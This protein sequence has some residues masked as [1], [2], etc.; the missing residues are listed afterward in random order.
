MGEC[1]GEGLQWVSTVHGAH[2][3]TSR[4]DVRCILEGSG[5][6]DGIWGGTNQEECWQGRRCFFRE[7]FMAHVEL[8]LLHLN[9]LLLHYLEQ[10]QI[11]LH[12]LNSLLVFSYFHLRMAVLQ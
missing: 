6:R 10:T 9:D 2:L 1:L 7:V 3:K 8:L 11:K 4:Q 12:Q 5:G